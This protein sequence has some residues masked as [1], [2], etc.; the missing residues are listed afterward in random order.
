[1]DSGGIFRLERRSAQAARVVTTTKTVWP[2]FGTANN[3]EEKNEDA[4]EQ[5]GSRWSQGEG[6]HRAKTATNVGSRT[7]QYGMHGG[8]LINCYNVMFSNLASS[9]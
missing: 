8:T 9:R 2:H 5:T 3:K 7:V 4:G 6:E 1:M